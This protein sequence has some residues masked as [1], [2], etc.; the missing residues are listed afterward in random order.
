MSLPVANDPYPRLK[1]LPASSLGYE[2]GLN[3]RPMPKHHIIAHLNSS[4]GSWTHVSGPQS[5][6]KHSQ[7]Q[8]TALKAG[9]RP[10]ESPMFI[11]YENWDPVVGGPEAVLPS[12]VSTR[13]YN[14]LALPR[15]LTEFVPHPHL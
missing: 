6:Q 15:L 3:L 14:R 11:P 4:R 5:L 7:P 1:L 12:L 2:I 13:T 8:H 10:L 9:K